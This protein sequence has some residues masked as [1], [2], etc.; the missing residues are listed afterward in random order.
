VRILRREIGQLGYEQ[1]FVIYDRKDSLALVK[2]VLRPP[3]RRREE[4]PPRG[5]RSTYDHG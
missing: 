5:V 1:N 3:E 4:L 2:R